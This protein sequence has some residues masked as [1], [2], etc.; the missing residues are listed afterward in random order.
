MIYFD[1]KEEIIRVFII[2]VVVVAVADFVVVVDIFV[3]VEVSWSSLLVVVSGITVVKVVGRSSV[4]IAPLV[5]G[6]L[7]LVKGFVPTAK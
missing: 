2:F 5:V 3:L 7:H 1:F 4:V 6:F